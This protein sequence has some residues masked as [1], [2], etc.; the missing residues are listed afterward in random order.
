MGRVAW[1]GPFFVRLPRSLTNEPV[2]T[3]ARNCDILP[4]FVGRKFLVHNGKDYLPVN[5]TE[6]MVGHKLGDFSF[7]KKPFSYK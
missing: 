3:K 4:N 6:Q 7:T 1:K 5:V 2:R